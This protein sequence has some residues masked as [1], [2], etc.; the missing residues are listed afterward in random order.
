MK[1]P[2]LIVGLVSVFTWNAFSKKHESLITSEK[3]VVFLPNHQQKNSLISIESNSQVLQCRF[4]SAAGMSQLGDSSW[5][6]VANGATFEKRMITLFSSE[7]QKVLML[8]CYQTAT[9]KPAKKAPLND[10]QVI[11]VLRS[12][13]IEVI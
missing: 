10:Q 1:I 4:E 11:E 7:K 13:S 2:L 3:K 8:N 12:A 5:D 9:N 6:I